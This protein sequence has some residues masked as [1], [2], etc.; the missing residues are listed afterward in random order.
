MARSHYAR[1]LVLSCLAACAPPEDL[2]GERTPEGATT[3][4]GLPGLNVDLH[5]TS[6]SGLSSGAFMAV[7]FHVAH[8]S[9]M[10]GVGVF[11]G[12][13]YD[14]AQGSETTAVTSCMVDLPSAPDPAA[15]LSTTEG[16]AHAGA[17]D[18][19]AHLDNQR[20]FLFGGADDHTVDPKVMDS[21]AAY[22][23]KVVTHGDIHYVSRRAGTAHTMPTLNYGGSCDTTASPYIGNC[24]YDGAGNA[25]AEIYGPL[26]PAAKTAGGTFVSIDQTKFITNPGSHSLADTGY[27]YVPSACASGTLCRVH[28][29]FHGCEQFATSSVGDAFYKHAGYNEWADTNQL[30][31]LYPQTIAAGSS[32]PNGCWDWWGYDSADYAKKSGPQIQMVRAMIDQ[33]ASGGVGLPA[34]ADGG[35]TPASPDASG[36][37][38]SGKPGSV[39]FVDNNYQHVVAGRAHLSFGYALANGSNQNM[40]LFTLAVTT[41]LQ[42]VGPNDFVIA[43]CP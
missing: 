9:I 1:A 20:V 4:G 7:Q 8:S 40:G 35:V 2:S 41:S 34:S 29:V 28:V 24:N 12:G 17:I 13:P 11:A 36:A 30:I 37:S 33:L 25:L 18:D 21:L 42:Q 32:N 16:Y 14:C 6:T 26:Q 15:L 43:N 10:R 27:A 22:Y 31:V 3:V 5:Q 19:P 38:Q 23:A 39:C